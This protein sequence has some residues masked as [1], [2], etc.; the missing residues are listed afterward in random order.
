MYSTSGTSRTLK[1]LNFKVI[2]EG[3]VG[4]VCMILRLRADRNI[5][6]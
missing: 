5:I 4:F 3:Y 6:A 2:I 1:L